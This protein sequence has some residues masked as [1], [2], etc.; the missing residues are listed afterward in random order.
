MEIDSGQIDRDIQDIFEFFEIVHILRE[1]I[2][3]NKKVLKKT[4][5]RIF[6]SIRARAFRFLKLFCSLNSNYLFNRD[7]N[8]FYHRNGI[9]FFKIINKDIS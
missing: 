9:H 5:K 4:I 2:E 8:I 3:N 7:S 6:T 1:D